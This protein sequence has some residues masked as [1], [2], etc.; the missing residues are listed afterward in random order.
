MATVAPAFS[1]HVGSSFDPSA[2]LDRCLA[3]FEGAL[4]RR[5]QAAVEEERRVLRAGLV[6]VLGIK[7]GEL[8]G[9]S[10]FHSAVEHGGSNHASPFKTGFANRES[11]T[12]SAG[13]AGLWRQSSEWQRPLFEKPVVSK[14]RSGDDILR[15]ELSPR[16]EDSGLTGRISDPL[17]ATAPSSFNARRHLLSASSYG[18]S[19]G[20]KD[21]LSSHGPLR[22]TR[23][24]TGYSGRDATGVV[25]SPH[26]G[27][28]NSPRDGSEIGKATRDTFTPEPRPSE[29]RA[30]APLY[31]IG[32]T[33]LDRGP[34]SRAGDREKALSALDRLEAL[35]RMTSPGPSSTRLVEETRETSNGSRWRASSFG[36]APRSG[37]AQ[38]LGGSYG[39]TPPAKPDTG[40]RELGDPKDGVADRSASPTLGRGGERDSCPQS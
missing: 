21:H 23:T 12:G 16:R 30:S 22:A 24:P 2:A 20:A 3:D 28:R 33:G 1:E 37:A 19:A 11:A 9:S 10:H 14:W 18:M 8:F 32:S 36:A 34:S 35:S 29:N 15:S 40:E 31:G 17:S 25:E 27:M 5:L 6:A 39:F 4:Q 13:S 38:R 7:E 26:N